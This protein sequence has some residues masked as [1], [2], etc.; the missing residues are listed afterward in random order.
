[1]DRHADRNNQCEIFFHGRNQFFKC[2]EY[3]TVKLSEWP[4]AETADRRNATLFP[5][6]RTN[7][8]GF[9]ADRSMPGLKH[10]RRVIIIIKQ[11]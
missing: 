2:K 10:E 5:I 9:T 4:L 8:K 1:M 3:K 6:K 11:A 7:Y